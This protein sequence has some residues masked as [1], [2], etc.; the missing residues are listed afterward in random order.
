MRRVLHLVLLLS[1]CMLSK[2][3][4]SI[5]I[6]T[7]CQKLDSGKKRQSGQ[8]SNDGNISDWAPGKIPLRSDE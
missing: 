8:Q 2:L 1:V 4:K 3:I 6:T 5:E 7:S